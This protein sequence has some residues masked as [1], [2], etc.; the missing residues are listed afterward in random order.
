MANA[1]N[2]LTVAESAATRTRWLLR[3]QA[4]V[5]VALPV[6]V[7]HPTGRFVAETLDVG[8]G[9]MFIATTS[10]LAYETRVEITVDLPG[11]GCTL[12]L[13]GVVRWK[14]ACGLGVQFLQLGARDTHTIVTLLES[15][16][17]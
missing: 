17:R 3:G 14:S 6:G 4:R 9:G 15:L 8:L 7:E 11:V 5:P 13:T 10:V 1:P 2:D 16:P 12:R